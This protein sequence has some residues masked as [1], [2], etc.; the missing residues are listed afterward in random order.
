ME[1]KY[2][3]EFCVAKQRKLDYFEDEINGGGGA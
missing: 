2:V 3:K 1:L